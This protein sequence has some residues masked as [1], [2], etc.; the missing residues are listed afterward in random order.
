MT[1]TFREI[2]KSGQIAADVSQV[3]DLIPSSCDR[4][5]VHYPHY[6]FMHP[7]PPLS[8]GNVGCCVAAGEAEAAVC[9]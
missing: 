6:C 4:K 2:W 9:M 1:I 8:G 7:P 5:G 3:A